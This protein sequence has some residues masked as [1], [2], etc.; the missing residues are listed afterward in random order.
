MKKKISSWGQKNKFL[1][2]L[3]SPQDYKQLLKSIKS[4]SFIA[5]GNGRSYGDSSI[6]YKNTINMLNFK[7]I[8]SFDIEKGLITVE[9]GILM[10][11]LLP[12]IL[13]HNWFLPVTPGTKNVS[14]GGLIASNVHGKNHHKV[15]S[16]QNFIKW[17]N[18]LLPNGK[19]VK[20]S[21]HSNY[22]L[23]FWTIGGMGMTGIITTVAF[24]LKKINCDKLLTK[25]ITFSNI[26]ETIRSFDKY[27]DWDYSVAWVDLANKKKFGKSV[28][29]LANHI[30]KKTKIENYKF[31]KTRNLFFLTFLSP[32]FNNVFIKIFNSIYFFL[33]SSKRQKQ[34]IMSIDNYFYP[35]D[36]IN[37][38]S[39]IYGKKGLVQ[40]QFVLPEKKFKTAIYEILDLINNSKIVPKLVV[41]KKMANETRKGISFPMRGYTMALDFAY[42]NK[43]SQL[44]KSFDSIIMKYKGR[45]YLTK[46]Y[47]LDKES[48][49][50][51]DPDMLKF[52]RFLK[53]KSYYLKINSLQ[54]NRFGF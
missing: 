46:D 39:D 54:F 43:V 30:K 27:Q 45:I 8:N 50:K 24:S 13:E 6:N 19:T 11:D 10:R 47:L 9:A 34:E 4:P 38:W 26:D 3:S 52:K 15:G 17:F 1:V 7:K 16:F 28:L 48:I 44:F 33:N 12:I 29:I 42:S 25:T 20:C 31:N 5:R 37:N 18:L 51:M 32:F 40:Y 53:N 35:L 14:A 2:N 41:L 22:K 36:K 21:R 23:F 49:Y